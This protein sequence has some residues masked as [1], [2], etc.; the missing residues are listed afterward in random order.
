MLTD[1]EIMLAAQ[2][3]GAEKSWL[4]TFHFGRTKLLAFGRAIAEKAAA[5]ERDRCAAV[6]DDEA[7]IREEAARKHPEDSDSRDRCNAAAR[8]AINCAK[9]V[10]NGE[11][12]AAIRKRGEAT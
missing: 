1:E 11:V 6:C 8:A 10:R 2:A 4:D 3:A 9:G 7:R 5:E 12:V